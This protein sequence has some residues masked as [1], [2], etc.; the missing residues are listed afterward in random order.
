MMSGVIR[1]QA[2]AARGFSSVAASDKR[3]SFKSVIAS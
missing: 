1:L 3:H 2:G